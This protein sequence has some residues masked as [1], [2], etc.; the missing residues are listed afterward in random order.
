GFVPVEELI[1]GERIATGHGF[2]DLAHDVL[3]G[4]LLGDG[5]IN[6]TSSHFQL[7]HSSRQ[8]AYARWKAELLAELE[9][10]VTALEVA[11]VAG[12]PRAYGAVQIRT[13][14]SRALRTLRDAFYRDRKRV[15]MWLAERMNDRML[16][17]WFL[18]DGYMRHRV[19][20]RSR[21]E[22]ATNGF[23]Y[24]DLQ[25]LR[26][27]LNRLGLPAKTSRGRIYFDADTSRL[28]SDRLA[29]YTPPSI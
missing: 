25:V 23:G 29:P 21:A 22:I 3:C 1:D 12:G 19:D 6:A 28:L 24:S 5:S 4:T 20:R 7:A 26:V 14:A 16:A 17:I 8:E 13:R 27:A 18:D 15:P 9:P 11:A 2:S 10:T